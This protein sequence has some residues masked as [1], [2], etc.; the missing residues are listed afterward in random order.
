[1][2]KIKPKNMYWSMCY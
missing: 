1:M 2:W